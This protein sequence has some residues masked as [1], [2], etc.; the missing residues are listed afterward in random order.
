MKVMI[1]DDH[2]LI[3][4][5]IILL[6]EN[7][8]EVEVVYDTGDGNE[9]I[10]MTGKLEPDIVLL[11]LSMPGGLDG[12]VT[13]QEIR[14]Q[15]PETK[16]ILL[17]MH[18]EEVY[19][20]KAVQIEADGYIL[21][22][23]QGSELY[24]ALRSVY[25]G[26][27]YYRVGF[28]EEQLDKMFRHKESPPSILTLREQEIVRLTVLGYTNKQIS[29]KLLISPKTVEN[30]KANIMQKLQMKNKHELIQYGLQND[31]VELKK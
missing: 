7:Y 28:S 13:A 30:H 26:K 12:F 9:A 25:N 17:T 10:V 16:I 8:P 11:D 22:R 29:E 18:D 21:K 19:I 6:L 15:R 1:V 24:D 27:R 23:G 2:A 20:Q 5:G 3:R 14:K 4:K 31:Y